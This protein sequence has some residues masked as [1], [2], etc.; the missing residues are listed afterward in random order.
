MGRGN[1]V[2]VLVG[3]GDAVMELDDFL[4]HFTKNIK[5]HNMLSGAVI[6][7]LYITATLVEINHN[8]G[9]S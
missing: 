8:I 7:R 4:N 5:I 2:M 9:F 1:A 6:T 3:R